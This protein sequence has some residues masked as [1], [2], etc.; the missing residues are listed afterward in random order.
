MRRGRHRWQPTDCPCVRLD[1][2][3]RTC[4]RRL[5]LPNAVAILAEG[6]GAW[7]LR[8]QY[9]LGIDANLRVRLRPWGGVPQQR[10]LRCNVCRG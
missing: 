10:R 7:D 2:L 8:C 3:Q 5:I 1:K 9:L 4:C 6:I